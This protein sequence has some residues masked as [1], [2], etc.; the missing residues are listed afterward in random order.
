IIANEM[1]LA[2]Y[3]KL[4]LLTVMGSELYEKFKDIFEK[5]RFKRANINK[6][7]FTPEE[8]KKLK[9]AVEWIE[10]KIEGKDSLIKFIPLEDYT[11]D[12]VEKVVKKYAPRGYRRW[13]IDTAKPSEGGNKERWQ[14]F[15]EDFDRLY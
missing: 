12:N 8:L 5:P 11:M 2:Q 6:G 13:I 4:L 14:Q 7:N 10:E 15:V 9:M 1:D 3:R